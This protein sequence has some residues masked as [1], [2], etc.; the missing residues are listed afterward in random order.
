MRNETSAGINEQHPAKRTVDRTRPFGVTAIAF[1]QLV[2][3]VSAIGGWW[4]SGPFDAGFRDAAVYLNSLSVAIAGIGLIVVV[5]LLL[6]VKWA[7]PLALFVLSV[8]LAVGLWAYYH[9]H[10]NFITMVLS[11]VAIFYLNSRDVRGSFGF[12]NPR[13]TVPIE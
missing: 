11:V 4:V 10:P 5:G 3:S 12:I 7:W 2:S 1:I 13:E 8:Q 9:G 6:M